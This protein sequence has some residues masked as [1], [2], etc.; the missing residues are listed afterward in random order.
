MR[1]KNVIKIWKVEWVWT[2]ILVSWL[3]YALSCMKFGRRRNS[4]HSDL[5][6]FWRS[7][8]IKSNW[9]S[10]LIIACFV[11]PA[12][13][14]GLIMKQSRTE[15]TMCVVQEQWNEYLY[16]FFFFSFIMIMGIEILFASG[17]IF[18]DIS[19]Q[20][21]RN[22]QELSNLISNISIKASL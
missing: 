13:N 17:T 22:W 8:L 11:R 10:I 3:C 14:T 12:G 1:S 20:L 21:S 18:R 4:F 9:R 15:M 7:E 6:S 2:W 19:L 5:G 16:Y